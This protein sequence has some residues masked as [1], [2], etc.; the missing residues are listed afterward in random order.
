MEEEEGGGV[1]ECGV[2]LGGAGCWREKRGLYV[3][4]CVDFGEIKDVCEC[5]DESVFS[6]CVYSAEAHCLPDSEEDSDGDEILQSGAIICFLFF[7]VRKSIFVLFF[8]SSMLDGK[9][10]F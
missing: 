6:Y 10:V 5:I 4:L 3:G 7:A 8:L 1:E 9:F 2:G